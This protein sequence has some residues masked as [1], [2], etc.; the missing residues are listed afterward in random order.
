[1][2]DDNK[3]KPTEE[4]PFPETDFPPALQRTLKEKFDR[5]ENPVIDRDVFFGALKQAT[6]PSPP[7]TE[8]SGEE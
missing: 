4:R 6:P 3:N 7:D 2:P 5:G 1:M 8:P